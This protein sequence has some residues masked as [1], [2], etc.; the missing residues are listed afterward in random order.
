MADKYGS[1]IQKLMTVV[2]DSE[3]EEFVQKL[4]WAEL[5]RLGDAVEEF[6]DK[7]DQSVDPQ[8]QE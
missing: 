5:R 2:I 3:Q 1:Y 8:E 6:L 7:H 4:A